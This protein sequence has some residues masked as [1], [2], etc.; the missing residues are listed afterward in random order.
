MVDFRRTL[1]QAQKLKV[2]RDANFICMY[3]GDPA[4]EVDHIFPHSYSLNDKEENLAA[5][6]TICNRIAS[7]KVFD[8]FIEKQTYIREQREKARWIEAIHIYRSM[9]QACGLPLPPV[10][11]EPK[12]KEKPK[13]KQRRNLDGSSVM[14]KPDL[15]PR[16]KEKVK[17]EKQVIEFDRDANKWRLQR[18]RAI[19]DRVKKSGYDYSKIQAYQVCFLAK[20][21]KGESWR[22]IAVKYGLHPNMARLIANGYEP[23]NKIRKKLNLSLIAE[24]E[25]LDENFPDGSQ[26]LGAL[27][28]GCGQ[29]FVSN[30]PKRKKCFFCTPF[31]PR[32]ILS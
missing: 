23:G 27:Q 21:Q 20:H 5:S 22:K 6:C 4:N 9:C 32:K 3:C 7:D 16:Y 25:T 30:H 8:G 10:R 26:V 18:Y 24:V 11:D 12:K 15:P 19:E 2:L 31:R 14:K 13:Q 17:K 28:C 1:T 29:W